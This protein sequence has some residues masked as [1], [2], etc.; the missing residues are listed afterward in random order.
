MLTAYPHREIAEPKLLQNL[1]VGLLRKLIDRREIYEKSRSRY[2][3]LK[4]SGH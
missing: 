3:R 4:E 2:E 1:M